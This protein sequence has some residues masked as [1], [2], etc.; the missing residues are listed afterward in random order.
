MQKLG[1]ESRFTAR[2][3]KPEVDSP[4]S[5][6]GHRGFVY[7]ADDI[8]IIVKNGV[9]RIGEEHEIVIDH[10]RLYSSGGAHLIG[11]IVEDTRYD[12][13]SVIETEIALQRRHLHNDFTIYYQAL[14]N[15]LKELLDVPPTPS[16][17]FHM[18]FQ[19]TM[20]SYL[21]LRTPWSDY[22]DATLLHRNLAESG[23]DG[24]RIYELSD[25]IDT[26]REQ[27]ANLHMEMMAALF[28]M[29]HGKIPRVISSKDLLEAGFDDSAEPQWQDYEDDD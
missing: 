6:H 18:L 25:Q 13:K 24:K 29:I 12:F 5:E 2:I 26:I 15:K 16:T 8:Q 20:R 10:A 3:H 14:L 27:N 9:N 4:H 11:R 23:D 21:S 28:E 1:L 17:S 22:Q 19:S 7:L